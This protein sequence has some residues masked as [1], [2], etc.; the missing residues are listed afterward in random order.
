V[1]ATDVDAALRARELAAAK[2][3]KEEQ[4]DETDEDK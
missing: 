1:V 2:A 4:S 3:E